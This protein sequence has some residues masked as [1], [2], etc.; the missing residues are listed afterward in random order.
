[1]ANLAA[2][3]ITALAISDGLLVTYLVLDDASFG[4]RLAAGTVAGLAVLAHLGFLLALAL[5]LNTASITLTALIVMAILAWLWW[6]RGARL[7]ADIAQTSWR[8]NAGSLC[9]WIVWIGLLTWIFSRVA[10]FKSDGLHTSPAANFGDLAFHLSG[11]TSFAYGDNFPPRSPIFAGLRFTYPFLI[12]FLA[13]FFLRTGAS[14]FNALFVVNLPLSLALVAITGDLTRRLVRPNRAGGLAARLAPVILFLS[15]GFGFFNFLQDMWEPGESMPGLLA[16]L[17]RTYTIGDDLVT[18]WG[19]VP[20]RW[21]NLVTTLIVPQRSLLFGLPLVALVVILWWLAVDEQRDL[22]QRRRCMLAAGVLTGLMPLLHAHGFFAVAIASLAVT[23][24]FRSRTWIGYYA[25]A[26]ILAGPQALWL[27]ATQVRGKLFEP[28][29]GWDKGESPLLL[30]WGVNAGVLIFLLIAALARPALIVKSG[31]RF[32]LPFIL[33]FLMPNIF[34]FAPWP[35]DN[36]KILVYWALLSCPFVAAAC[37]SLLGSERVLSR[38]AGGLAVVGLTFAGALDVTRALSPVEHP[39]LLNPVVLEV[40]R[41][42]RERI[43]PHSVI[44]H[45]PIHNSPVIMTGRQSLMGYPGHLWTHGIDYEE[46]ESDV[47]AI[48]SGRSDADELLKKYGVNYVMVGPIE[49]SQLKPQES[50]F[51]G[52]EFP[53][54]IDYQGYRVYEIRKP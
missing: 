19:N 3:L 32:Y 24:L 15:G 40:A 44:M 33:W 10:V 47:G 28:H 2:Y 17:P 5:G 1:M 18:P 31:R 42:I 16:H 6:K 50:F 39:V 45:A 14:L 36:I 22:G 51:I 35:W 53:V 30:F 38:M 20:L 27:S 49:R 7:R 41:M 48:Y 21:G 54:I 9:Y 11:I 29:F 26:A 8:I 25:A 52:H 4:F 23:A 34:L 13:A 46:R 37:A 12:D 43:P